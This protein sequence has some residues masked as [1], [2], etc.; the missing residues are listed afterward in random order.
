MNEGICER[1]RENLRIVYKKKMGIKKINELKRTTEIQK[2]NLER[3]RE[4]ERRK[5][6]E[7]VNGKG[8]EMCVDIKRREIPREEKKGRRG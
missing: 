7:G 1:A 3:E 4:D 6:Q 2:V 5:G 8:Y